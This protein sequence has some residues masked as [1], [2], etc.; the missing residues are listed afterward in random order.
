MIEFKPLAP[1][2]LKFIEAQPRQRMDQLGMLVPSYAAVIAD[3]IALSAW[4]GLRCI[5]AG[6]VVVL[7]PNRL[8]LA[9]C[10]LSGEAR[11]HMVAI[12]LKIAHVIDRLPEERIELTVADGFEDG[13][14]WAKAL[15]FVCETPIPLRKRGAHGEDEYI[16]ARVR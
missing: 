14:K 3:N 5:A 2:H 1:E 4:S 16:Y 6:G 10:L 12:S 13:H 15:G 7:I 11:Q 9:W 8:A